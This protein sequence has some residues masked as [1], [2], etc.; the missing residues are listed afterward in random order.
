MAESNAHTQRGE[1]YELLFVA[2]PLPMWVFEIDGGRFLAVNAQACAQYGYSE[3]EFLAMTI[4]DIRLPEEGRHLNEVRSTGPSGHR[5][6][7]LW[8]HRRKDGRLIDVEI[9][10]DDIVFHGKQARLVL[11]QD[12]TARARMEADL[13]LSQDRFNYVTRATEDAVWDRDIR[14]NTIWWN[15]NLE[16]LFGIPPERAGNTLE[17]ARERIHPDDREQVAAGVAQA[18][19]S[20]AEQWSGEY[21]FRRE[22]GSYAFVYDR[23]FVIRE[24][25][26]RAVR[27]VG[28]ITDL[29]DRK[30]REDMLREQATLLDQTTDAILVRGMDR[31][32]RYWNKA[33]EDM[34]GISRER[35]LGRPVD[36]I[37]VHEDP[38][39]FE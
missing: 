28:A 29:S 38:A 16:L 20:G 24:A 4:S 27:V 32:I 2:N 25:S 36:E 6:L 30:L 18:I 21:R 34:Y 15:G 35:A 39:I 8:K 11:A 26:G 31:R 1:Y 22:D 14:E 5:Q 33:A 23:S 13:R 17:W 37:V 9:T 19:K 7:G 3:E 10:S 12:V